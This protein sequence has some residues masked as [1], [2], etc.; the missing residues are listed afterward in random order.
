MTFFQEEVNH[1]NNQ[2]QT[3]NDVDAFKCLT[4]LKKKRIKMT[5]GVITNPFCFLNLNLKPNLNLT[6]N[7]KP[8]RKLTDVRFELHCKYKT[9]IS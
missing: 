8:M 9:R 1:T 6:Q 5:K 3:G 4:I 7:Q 2:Q